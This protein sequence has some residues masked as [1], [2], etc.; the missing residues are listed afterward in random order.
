MKGWKLFEKLKDE[1]GES[2]LLDS[3]AQALSDD[4]LY[5]N[6][7]YIARMNDIDIEEDC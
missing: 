7:E 5:D 1:L 4:E 3:L 2:Y 6:M